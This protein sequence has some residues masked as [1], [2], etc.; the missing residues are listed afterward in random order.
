MSKKVA[1]QPLSDNT[2]KLIIIIAI[3]LVAVIILSISLALILKTEEKTPASDSTD[4]SNSSTLPIKNGDFLYSNTEATAYPHTAVNWTKYA[5]KA[6]SGSHQDFEYITTTEKSV[7]GIID[8]SNDNWN[9]VSNDITPVLP[10]GV[11]LQ[12]PG[13]HSEDLDDDNVYMIYNKEAANASIL[14]DSVSVSTGASVRITVWLN[15]KYIK[16]G[17]AVIMIQKSNTYADDEYWYA[18]HFEIGYAGDSATADDNG[19]QKHEFYIF[20]RETSTQYVKVNVGLGNVYKNVNAEG[21]LYVDD[22]TYETVTADEYRQ[23]VD[24]NNNAIENTY[25]PYKILENEDITDESTYSELEI[26]MDA[27]SASL[28]PYTTSKEYVEDAKYSPFT[29]RDDFQDDK[30]G[31]MIYKLEQKK[32]DSGVMALRMKDTFEMKASPINKDHYHISFW[33]RVEKLDGHAATKANVYIQQQQKDG[34]WKDLESFTSITTSQDIETDDKCGWVKYDVYL[35][36]ST[37]D[38]DT[39]AILFVLGN[40]D[41]YDANDPN[42]MVPR[43]S[44][45]VTTPA[46]EK[47]SYKDYNNASN[48]SYVKKI[49]LVGDSANTTVTNG[50]FSNVN[51]TGTQPTSWTPV[52]AGDN[53]I[54]KDGKGDKLDAKYKETSLVEGSGVNKVGS[55]VDDAQKSVLQISTKGTNFGY[56]S[57]DITL[58]AHA[59]YVISVVVKGTPNIYLVDN[60]KDRENAI[61]ARTEK[62]DAETQTSL[63]HYFD[64]SLD[65]VT[66]NVDGWVRYYMVYVTGDSNATLR[67]ALFNGKIDSTDGTDLA[68]GTVLYD[69]VK[70]ERIGTYS[71]V[72]P[73]DYDEDSE[74]QQYFDISFSAAS[75]YSDALKDLIGKELTV[76]Y[77]DVFN[78]DSEILKSLTGSSVQPTAEEWE[79]MATIPAKEDDTNKDDGDDTTVKTPSEVDWGLLMSVLSSIILVAALLIVFVLKVFQNKNRNRKA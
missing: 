39:I 1:T 8:V 77:K 54:Y 3:I 14:S 31:F 72:E 50:S 18:Y 24:E 35:K 6:K 38:I 17:N 26:A 36:P 51:S 59:I 44:L 48:G 33:L 64:Y 11:T 43:G 28:K 55:A 16:S 60:S 4:S 57:N 68:N 21:I 66:D 73:E 5:Y 49:D 19:W 62:A 67:I 78:S 32:G 7:M 22:I 74:E 46:W 47:I 2:R 10:E 27:T 13:K 40:K 30:T 70:M 9:E 76:N 61:V 56:I 25:E 69:N 58:S 12:N 65:E 79:E 63:D 20:N 23:Q 52:F 71:L 15:A 41:G 75:G 42:G 45:Y 37:A 53:A 34:E 29:N